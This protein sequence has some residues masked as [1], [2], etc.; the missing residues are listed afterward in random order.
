MGHRFPEAPGDIVDGDTDLLNSYG[1][2]CH[3]DNVPEQQE[4][5]ARDRDPATNKLKTSYNFYDPSCSADKCPVNETPPRPWD[6]E[7]AD[8]LQFRR[9]A[10]GG[11]LF[12]SQITRVIPLTEANK[13]MN[14]RFQALLEKT[15]WKNY[16]LIGTQWPSSFP[17][18][19][20]SRRRSPTMA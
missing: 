6:P 3:N 5:D 16:M 11:M 15:V 1:R 7:P 13:T 20:H 12:N 18:T 14:T 17:C 4:V 8:E 10:S 9:A 2:V 19:T